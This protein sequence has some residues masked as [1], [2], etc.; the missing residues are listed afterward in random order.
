MVFSGFRVKEGLYIVDFLIIDGTA[1][2]DL[3]AREES[4]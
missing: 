3:S 4:A 1:P 2:L